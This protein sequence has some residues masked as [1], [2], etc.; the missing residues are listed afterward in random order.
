MGRLLFVDAAFAVGCKQ[1][2]TSRI[3]AQAA[4]GRYEAGFPAG[5]AAAQR[6]RDLYPDGF[7]ACFQYFSETGAC[8]TLDRRLDQKTVPVVRSGA[9]RSGREEQAEGDGREE[10]AGSGGKQA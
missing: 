4:G 7:P 2:P 9:P 8:G 5:F 1:V 3:E 10:Q 6:F